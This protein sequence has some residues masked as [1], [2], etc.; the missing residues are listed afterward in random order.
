MFVRKR[1]SKKS[2]FAHV[3]EPADKSDQIQIVA[4]MKLPSERSFEEKL[5]ELEV[6]VYDE[7]E[8]RYGIDVTQ[9]LTEIDEVELFSSGNI[10]ISEIES[11]IFIDDE[12]ISVPLAKRECYDNKCYITLYSL[13]KILERV[14]EQISRLRGK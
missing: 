2:T 1:V 11:K 4:D 8:R 6:K 10:R 13:K 7:L 14:E 12:I 3:A 5:V 9:Y